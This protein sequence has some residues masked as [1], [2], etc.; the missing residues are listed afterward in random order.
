MESFDKADGVGKLGRPD[1]LAGLDK[2]DRPDRFAG[3]SS[4]NNLC[5]L[6]ASGLSVLADVSGLD[7]VSVLFGL[8]G[9]SAANRTLCFRPRLGLSFQCL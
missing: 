2:A 9:A 4:D 7:G 5:F 6:W 8:S 1:R 3:L